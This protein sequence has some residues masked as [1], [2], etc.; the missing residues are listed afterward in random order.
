MAR[1][2]KRREREGRAR[3]YHRTSRRNGLEAVKVSSMQD[4]KSARLFYI[5]K[6]EEDINAPVCLHD[7]PDELGGGR[8]LD[9]DIVRGASV[10]DE[11]LPAVAQLQSVLLVVLVISG[12]DDEA[13][14]VDLG[15]EVVVVAIKAKLKFSKLSSHMNLVMEYRQA[16]KHETLRSRRHA[17]QNFSFIFE[18][19]LQTNSGSTQI[20]CVSFT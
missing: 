8:N 12:N 13:E 3:E 11:T 16:V 20:R 5:K 14:A 4:K 1:T 17:T 15:A 19:S 10:E 9:D 18:R 7:G 2:G 6:D